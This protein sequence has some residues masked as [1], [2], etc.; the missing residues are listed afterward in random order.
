MRLASK[1]DI[2]DYFRGRVYRE[3]SD[4]QQIIN[5]IIVGSKFDPTPVILEHF[6]DKEIEEEYLKR[7]AL[8]KVLNE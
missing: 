4:V 1:F 8:G 6:T 5:A 2:P 7:T 3:P